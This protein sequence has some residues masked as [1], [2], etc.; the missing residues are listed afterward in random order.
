MACCSRCRAWQP[1]I[2]AASASVG[3]I[4]LLPRM[5]NRPGPDNVLSMSLVFQASPR[6]FFWPLRLDFDR[7]IIVLTSLKNETGMDACL[8]LLRG[9]LSNLGNSG[10]AAW[11]GMATAGTPRMYGHILRGPCCYDRTSHFANVRLRLWWFPSSAA[12]L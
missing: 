9:S 11:G 10:A 3:G 7:H 8:C 4:C 5:Q 1:G 2:W 12:A 6:H